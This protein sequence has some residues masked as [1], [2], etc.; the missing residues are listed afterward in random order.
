MSRELQNPLQ[1][2]HLFQ[3][4]AHQNRVVRGRSQFGRPAMRSANRLFLFDLTESLRR[5][6]QARSLTRP[7]SPG[8]AFRRCG[9]VVPEKEPYPNFLRK[10]A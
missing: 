3:C 8:E 1:M 5:G 2:R 9:V 4:K 6:G 10:S 7:Q